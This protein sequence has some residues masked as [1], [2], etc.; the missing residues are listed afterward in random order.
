[1]EESNGLLWHKSI[2]CMEIIINII[3]AIFIDSLANWNIEKKC[4]FNTEI[5]LNNTG[6]NALR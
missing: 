1:M 2:T 5:M 6:C 3:S 4:D